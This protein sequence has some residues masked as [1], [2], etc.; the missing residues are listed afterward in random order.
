MLCKCVSIGTALCRPWPPFLR[1]A[2]KGRHRPLDE[3][4]RKV[5]HDRPPTPSTPPTLPLVMHS[6]T[7]HLLNGCSQTP[8]LLCAIPV[9]GIAPRGRRDGSL[10]GYS[11]PALWPLPQATRTSRGSARVSREPCTLAA[12]GAGVP[13]GSSASDSPE[14]EV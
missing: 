12:C 7:S 3:S 13:L 10:A 6:H 4:R 9:S 11:I 14:V 8:G 5:S 2:A 1:N